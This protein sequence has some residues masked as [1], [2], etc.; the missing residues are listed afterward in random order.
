MTS[1][2]GGLE[3]WG[4]CLGCDV[5]DEEMCGDEMRGERLMYS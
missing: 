3:V 2:T 1:G 5:M 4:R